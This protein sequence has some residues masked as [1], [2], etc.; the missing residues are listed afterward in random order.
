MIR[1]SA[2]R[3]IVI[4]VLV[5][6]LVASLTSCQ[7][8]SPKKKN[9]SEYE[10]GEVFSSSRDGQCEKIHNNYCLYVDLGSTTKLFKVND[11]KSEFY[12]TE[13]LEE[14]LLEGHYI[15]CFYNNDFV[16]FCEEKPDDSRVYLSFEF[17]NHNVEYYEDIETV[18]TKFGN[19]I[20]WGS[21]CN[22]NA[23]DYEP[24]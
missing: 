17:S 19:D 5:I 12:Y 7:F 23:G 11:L 15:F 8:F 24:K 20:E 4:A 18:Y 13:Y 2:A 10:I 3:V 22:N 1:H 9:F 16:V 6:F 14:I 21:L